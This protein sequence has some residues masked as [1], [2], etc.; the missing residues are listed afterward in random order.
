MKIIKTNK[1]I[2]KQAGPRRIKDRGII[3]K[4]RYHERSQRLKD[5]FEKDLGPISYM[6]W[7]G[8]DYTTDSDYFVVVGPAVT[9]D[10][11]KRFFAGV[12]KLPKDPRAKVYAPS[13]EYFSTLSGALS[14]ASEKWAIPYPRNA[15]HYTLN[16]LAN[17]K[18]PRHVKGNLDMKIIKTAKYVKSGI[19]EPGKRDGTGPYDPDA[20]KEE[21]EDAKKNKCKR[22]GIRQRVPQKW[23][24]YLTC[25]P[26][27][28][29]GYQRLDVVFA[30]GSIQRDCVVLNAETI[31]LP[32]TCKGKVITDI[33]LNERNQPLIP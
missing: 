19:T 6:R 3:W 22:R 9:Q 30:D 8:H 17:I 14:H 7:E 33:R 23:A 20:T 11:K 31:E 5:R 26:E 24:D 10:L 1:N 27:S 15:P 18:I 12:K 2:Y 32:D 16:D 21:I 13:G 4:E 25:L 28:G 29:M